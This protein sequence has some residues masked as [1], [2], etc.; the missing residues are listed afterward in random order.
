MNTMPSKMRARSRIFA[1]RFLSLNMSTPHVNDMITEP[2]LTSDTTEIIEEGSLR[3]VKYTKSARQT[4]IDMS[5]I[6]HLHTNGVLFFLTGYHMSP[7]IT[8]M[9]MN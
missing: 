2:R 9:N 6:D 1:R 4:K 3:A 8:I 7:Q 5:G